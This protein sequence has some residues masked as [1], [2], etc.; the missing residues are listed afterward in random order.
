MIMNGCI[1]ILKNFRM[2][3]GRISHLQLLIEGEVLSPIQIGALNIQDGAGQK[4]RRLG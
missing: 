2:L 4:V 1:L 3:N